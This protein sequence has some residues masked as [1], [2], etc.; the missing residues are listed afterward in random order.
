MTNKTKFTFHGRTARR[1]TNVFAAAALLL[2]MA[3]SAHAQLLSIPTT[4]SSKF[5]IDFTGLICDSTTKEVTSDEP[6]VFLVVGNLVTGQLVVS[7]TGEFGD[8]D[9]GES[10]A[11]TVRIWGPT[12][13]ASAFPNGNPENLVILVAPMEHDDCDVQSLHAKLQSSLQSRFLTLRAQLGG[14]TRASLVTQLATTMAIQQQCSVGCL[15]CDRDQPIGR[16]EELHIT[17]R[18]VSNTGTVVM[19]LNHDGRDTGNGFYRTV[20]RVQGSTLTLQRR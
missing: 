14:I 2:T 20:F 11:Q 4:T 7:R 17:S 16:P 6:Y 8:V 15:F 12:G 3:F 13:V 19:T 5:T 1:I 18:N 9:T 10:R